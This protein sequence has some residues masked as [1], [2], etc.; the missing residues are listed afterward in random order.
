[1]I[2]YRGMSLFS[3]SLRRHTGV[4]EEECITKGGG[5][6]ESQTQIMDGHRCMK[7]G[8]VVVVVA[9]ALSFQSINTERRGSF[10]ENHTLFLDFSP[11]FLQRRWPFS[12]DYNNERRSKFLS[13]V[14]CLELTKKKRGMRTTD[15]SRPTQD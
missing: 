13:D 10:R 3:P 15:C 5:K 2:N 9:P 7:S 14:V 6:K 12:H 11:Q 8:S 4:T 1:M